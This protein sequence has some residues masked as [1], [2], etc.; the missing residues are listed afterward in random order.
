MGYTKLFLCLA[1]YSIFY[2]CIIHQSKILLGGIIADSVKHIDD[3]KWIQT[4]C[5]FNKNHIGVREIS[6]SGK[7]LIST[8]AATE[9]KQ[10]FPANIV[11]PYYGRMLSRDWN[12][13]RSW[14]AV[15]AEKT[16]YAEKDSCEYN[17]DN[18]IT[19][20]SNVVLERTSWEWHVLL[21][22][23]QIT[24]WITFGF[25]YVVIYHYWNKN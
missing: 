3:K 15:N 13:L 19:S 9:D 18:I 10:L 25:G 4:R 22:L 24:Y 5:S 1:G 6:R 23:L 7:V 12:Y 20:C 2:L 14:V 8:F 16:C 11:Y 21:R 17:E